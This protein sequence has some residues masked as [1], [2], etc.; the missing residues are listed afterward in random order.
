MTDV[1]TAGGGIPGAPEFGRL[2][3]R[4]VRELGRLENPGS[5]RSSGLPPRTPFLPPSPKK[6]GSES[7]QVLKSY[8]VPTLLVL[9]GRNWFAG[10]PIFR[11]FLGSAKV[12][13]E[14]SLFRRIPTGNFRRF[15]E[16]P[17]TAGPAAPVSGRC[18]GR[19]IERSGIGQRGERLQ[20]TRGKRS[21][22]VAERGKSAEGER[23][24]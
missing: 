4:G 6:M 8:Y 10:P 15:L 16:P 17:N 19:E 21:H 18:G 3:T 1:R 13:P 7:A 14:S 5:G 23:R 11:G 24:K 12:P 20:T 9:W 22:K 2:R